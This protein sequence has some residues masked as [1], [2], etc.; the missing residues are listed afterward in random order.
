[1][2]TKIGWTPN[3]YWADLA[4]TQDWK[5][6]TFFEPEPMGSFM[7]THNK[8]YHFS[9]CPAFTRYFHNSF[10]IRSPID[11]NIFVDMDRKICNIEH[12]NQEFY[13]NNLHVRWEDFAEGC[14]PIVSLAID[15]VFVTDDD[16]VIESAGLPMLNTP[17]HN[18]ISCVPGTFNIHK[19]VRP[20]DFTFT[21]K[22]WT[23]PI[24]IKRGDPLYMIK[25]RTPNE[26]SVD[27]T[28]VETTEKLKTTLRGTNKSRT[29][30]GK[31]SLTSRYNQA[32]NYLNT[33]QW[34][35]KPSLITKLK[36]LLRI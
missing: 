22:D 15:Y 1:M 34:F 3:P 25:F 14:D 29:I 27:L 11:I 28:R 24:Q 16:V 35:N 36:S 8:D 2:K 7:I 17:L 6:L 32:S 20:V 33:I 18:N 31:Q 26:N 30:I 10:L 23:K 5:L 21:V 13:D 4:T 12:Q 19:W 9:K